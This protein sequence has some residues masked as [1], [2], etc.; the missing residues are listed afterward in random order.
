MAKKTFFVREPLQHDG[1]SFAVGSKIAL[2]ANQAAGLL[3]AGVI[4]TEAAVVESTDEASDQAA[5]SESPA[6]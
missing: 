6:E 2:E 3:A 4:A 5:A 1:E